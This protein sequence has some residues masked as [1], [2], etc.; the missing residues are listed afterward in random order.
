VY[1]PTLANVFGVTCAAR[2]QS[3]I[4]KSVCLASAFTGAFGSGED[5]EDEGET[6]N[7]E[8]QLGSIPQ[9]EQ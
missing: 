9:C 2:F 5:S 8:M 7:P 4:G 1:T 3:C 6:L